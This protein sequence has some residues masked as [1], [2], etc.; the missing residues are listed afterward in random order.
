MTELLAVVVEHDAVE[1]TL[2]DLRSEGYY[3]TSRRIVSR[4]NDRVE[5]PLLERPPWI[6]S[7]TIIEQSEP[8]WRVNSLIERLRTAGWS[9]AELA[10]VPRS[11]AVIGTV[12]VVKLEGC[13]RPNEI[14]SVLLDIHGQA[15][16]VVDL[17]GID[18]DH[19]TP[20]VSVIAGT[21][22]TETIHREHGI[23]YALDVS[24]VMFSP[25]NK[26][27]RE[28]M[29]AVVTRSER[30]F[31][32]FAGIGYFTL[33]MARAGASVVAAEI[34]PTAYR[35]LAENAVLND[36]SDRIDAYLADCRTVPAS[37]DR[38]V[39][40]HYDALGYLETALTCIEPDGTIHVHSLQPKSD[41]WTDAIEHIEQTAVTFDRTVAIEDR[42]IIKSHSP[43]FDH[44][45][46][47]VHV[48]Q[49]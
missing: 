37:P 36:V 5:L 13:S 30:V 31:D 29:G 41:P 9:D 26:H 32:M 21:G 33:P 27:E 11:W 48:G 1:R 18:G 4:S 34:N 40:G 46:L 12:I 42:R 38:I 2:S 15:D 17:L 25:G 43:A 22:V 44:I 19:R 47:D 6:D 16:T 49:S 24:T 8:E 39:M 10:Q 14:G 7:D 23:Q 35:F 28:R 3:D 45:V 20:R